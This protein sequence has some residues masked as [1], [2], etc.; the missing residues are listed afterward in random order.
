MKLHYFFTKFYLL[1]NFLLIIATSNG[2]IKNP[3][4]GTLWMYL[5]IIF[6]VETIESQE[7]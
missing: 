7:G 1:L 5:A 2:Y 4:H 3:D 6:V